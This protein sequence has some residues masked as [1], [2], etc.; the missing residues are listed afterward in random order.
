[1]RSPTWRGTDSWR[2]RKIWTEILSSLFFV[3]TTTWSKRAIPSAASKWRSWSSLT[4]SSSISQ[5]KTKTRAKALTRKRATPTSRRHNLSR[6]ICFGNKHPK[7]H[8]IKTV[9]LTKSFGS[10]SS[11]MTNRSFGSSPTSFK[12]SIKT[13]SRST[14]TMC[15]DQTTIIARTFFSNLGQTK[16][17]KN[18]RISRKSSSF[19]ECPVNKNYRGHLW[20]TY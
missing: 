5:T 2:S 19:I 11:R 10:W 15:R 20:L 18:K 17:E 1:M 4:M 7:S 9:L 8:Q 3:S 6:P 12:I 13:S 14:E 16:G